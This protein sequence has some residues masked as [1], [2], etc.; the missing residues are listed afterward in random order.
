MAIRQWFVARGDKYEGPYPDEK[1][2]DLVGGGSV[3]ADTLIWCEGM[4]E[5][6]RAADVPGLMPPPLGVRPPKPPATPPGVRT[7]APAPRA[8][9]AAPAPQ[10]QAPEAYV[11]YTLSTTVEMWPL[12][13]RVILL[14]LSQIVIIPIPWVATSFFRW[15]IEHLELP[16]GERA[17]FTGKPGDIWYYFVLN[18]LCGYLGFVNSYLQLLQFAAS[19]FFSWMILRW[20]ISNLV[21]K[22][23]TQPARFTGDYL[24]MLGFSIL[25]PLSA[26]TI[27]GWAWVGTWWG[28]WVAGHIEGGARRLHFIATGWEYLWRTFVFVFASGFIIPIPWVLRW[29]TRWIVSQFALA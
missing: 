19:G 2:R 24:P 1:L 13:G 3:T 25:L 16:N 9:A 4:K 26:I 20:V 10:T 12:L 28:R 27:V 23:R 22:G 5:W 11:G 14:V 8:R 29:Y 7:A 15:F 6:A 18:A 21:W 17:T